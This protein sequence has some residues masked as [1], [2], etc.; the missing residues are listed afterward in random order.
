MVKGMKSGERL[1][2]VFEDCGSFLGVVARVATRR[3]VYFSKI[4]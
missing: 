1:R 3:S 2:R 4:Y